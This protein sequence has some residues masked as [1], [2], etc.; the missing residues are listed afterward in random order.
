V[1]LPAARF[2]FLAALTSAG[3][4]LACILAAFHR[5]AGAPPH[6]Q[7]TPSRIWADGYDEATLTIDGP[8]GIPPR[9]SISGATHSAT[10]GE[11]RRQAGRWEAPIRAGVMPGRAAI[12]VQ[13]PGEPP[14]DASLTVALSTL[15][16]R[17]DGTPDFLRLDDP[18]DQR[19]FVRWFTFLAEA[20]YFQDPAVRPAEINDCAALIRYAYREAL[21]AHNDAWSLQA[22]LP[23]IPALVSV[24]KYEYPYTAM[25]AALFR[26]QT[27]PFHESDLTAAVFTQFA[28]VKSLWRFNTY[29]VSRD[30]DRAQAGDLLFYRQDHERGA[31]TF[32]SMIYLGASQVR[33]DG[34]RYVLYHTGPQDEA[35]GEMRRLTVDELRHFPETEWLPDPGNPKFLG[36]YRWNILKTSEAQP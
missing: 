17:A 35:P 14:V 16:T 33:P 25:G 28:D 2:H 26:V 11:P 27:G 3:V 36:V 29:R 34:A 8:D 12:R 30:L 23:L 31:A 5:Q 32:H 21:H 24:A 15:D 19:S 9:I 4:G 13:F 1:R 7:L 6:I 18:R 22:H 10:A 20:Q